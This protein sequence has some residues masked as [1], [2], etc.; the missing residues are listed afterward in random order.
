MLRRALRSEVR[1]LFSRRVTSLLLVSIALLPLAL[2]VGSTMIVSGNA[3]SSSP[4]LDP[5]LTAPQDLLLI[6][7]GT[8][9]LLTAVLGLLSITSE[10]ST[11]TIMRTYQVFRRRHHVLFGKLISLAVL[12]LAA[13]VVAVGLAIPE[14][15][16]F[17]GPVLTPA[18]PWLLAA[19][20]VANGVLVALFGLGVGMVLSRTLPAMLTVVTFIYILPELV[21]VVVGSVLPQAQG[22]EG[23]LP[24][25]AAGALVQSA[26]HGSAYTGINPGLALLVA[27]AETTIVLAAGFWI[28][29]RR[30]VP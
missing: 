18:A 30:D 13:S 19:A 26:L 5:A 16:A 25:E 21:S 29:A 12:V 4:W 23:F 20:F 6:V 22:L 1:K 15:L 17:G 2:A 7:F 14:L 3:R 11:L 8:A 10:Y 27:L 9:N 24:T 28:Q